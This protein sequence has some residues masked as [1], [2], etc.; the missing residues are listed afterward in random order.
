MEGFDPFTSRICRDVRNQ[1]SESLMAAIG[2]RKIDPALIVA[3]KFLSLDV[4][5]E[6]VNYI[7]DRIRRYK[8]VIHQ[9]ASATSQ[10]DDVYRVAI[11]L[12][13]QELFFEVHEWLEKKW[14]NSQGAE[15][16]AVQALIRAAGAYILLEQGR[17]AGAKRLAAKAA[18][19]LIRQKDTVPDVVNVERLIDKL[20]TLDAVPPKLG[21]DQSEA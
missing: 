18:A 5:K 12:W 13:D 20:N 8:A 7:S 10:P 15:R 1:L 17:N 19:T 14:Q 2:S 16:D 21:S 3:E 6:V 4:G 9:V 11:W